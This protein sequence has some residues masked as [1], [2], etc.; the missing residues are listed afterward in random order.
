M[1]KY[2]K[3]CNKENSDENQYCM[4]CGFFLAQK[5]IKND[6]GRISNK[7]TFYERNKIQKSYRPYKNATFAILLSILVP[8]SAHIY[9]GKN[10]EG[11]ALLFISFILFPIIVIFLF[12]SIATNHSQNSPIGGSSSFF[13]EFLILSLV[14]GIGELAILAYSILDTKG[15]LDDY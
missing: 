7:Y 2:C 3:K 5:T 1:T 14:I 4:H 9:L 13:G 12:I 8:G 6:E 11:F 10:K 15:I